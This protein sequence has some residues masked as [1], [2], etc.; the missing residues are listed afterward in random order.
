M[1][2]LSR[3]QILVGKLL[4]CFLLS[5][6]QGLFLLGA[7]KLIFNMSWGPQPW[8]LL[9]VVFTTSLSAMGL[10]LLV[11]SMARTEAQVA[12]YGTLLVLVLAG[13]S[14]CLMG[15]REL[16]GRSVLDV[17][18]GLMW[19]RRYRKV[20]KVA[21]RGLALLAGERS[22]HRVRLLCQVALITAAAGEHDAA[23]DAFAE[24]MELASDLGDTAALV[25][26]LADRAAFHYYFCRLEETMADGRAAEQASATLPR[27]PSVEVWRLDSDGVRRPGALLLPSLEGTMGDATAVV[28]DGRLVVTYA[29]YSPGAQTGRR[30][31][32]DASCY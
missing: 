3:A 15:D 6:G 4:P 17:V 7:G 26:V 16:I 14:G 1:A 21:Q 24:A 25:R 22:A 12:I 20:V 11:A 2:P 5:L 31:L 19:A 27:P 10:A 28:A 13:L 23:R 32:V 29:D 8:W 30:L 9:P 18:D